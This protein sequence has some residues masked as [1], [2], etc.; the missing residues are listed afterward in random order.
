MGL[1]GAILS[2]IL[3]LFLQLCIFNTDTFDL[4][5]NPLTGKYDVEVALTLN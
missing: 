4:D 3:I 5:Q 2:F 1:F